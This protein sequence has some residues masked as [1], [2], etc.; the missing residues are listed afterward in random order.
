MCA[1]RGWVYVCDTWPHVISRCFFERVK[2]LSP[3]TVNICRCCGFCF[4]CCCR[5]PSINFLLCV[6]FLFFYFSSVCFVLPLLLLL[7]LARRPTRLRLL[8]PPPLSS[9]PHNMTVCFF[10]L[11][12]STLKI[13]VHTHIELHSAVECITRT[14]SSQRFFFRLFLICGLFCHIFFRLIFT[15]SLLLLLI[16]RAFSQSF[17]ISLAFWR[18]GLTRYFFF[19]CY[20]CCFV[21]SGVA[22]S[23]P[24]CV[25]IHSI[26]TI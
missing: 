18:S 10:S 4:D 13:W 1:R 19:C 26:S 9:L 20:C 21:F 25:V 6:Y 2:S 23:F 11:A 8:V 24:R 15:I 3:L 5:S 7:P 14:F 17:R 12:L 22:L 16:A